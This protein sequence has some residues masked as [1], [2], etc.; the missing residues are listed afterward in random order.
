VRH[1]WRFKLDD[2]ANCDSVVVS[3][4]ALSLSKNTFASN[5]G[6]RYLNKKITQNN[7]LVGFLICQVVID[8]ATLFNIAIHPDA[9]KQGFAS[10]LLTELIIELEHKNIH[11]LWLEVRASNRAAITLYEH[12]GFNEITIRKNYYPT[13][14]GREDAIIMAYTI[15]L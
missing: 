10:S 5:Q 14:Q 4:I 12:M 9:R 3:I 8:E 2:D 1:N 13:A 15:S 6:E 11:T 7:R